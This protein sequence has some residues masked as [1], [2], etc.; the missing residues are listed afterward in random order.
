MLKEWTDVLLMHLV[1]DPKTIERLTGRLE[2]RDLADITMDM[3]RGYLWKVSRDYYEHARQPI[4]QHFLVAALCD[5]AAQ[6]GMQPDEIDVIGALIDDMYQIGPSGLNSDVALG[7]A[8]RVLEE[9]RISRPVQEMLQDGSSVTQ[10]FDTFQLG[11]SAAAVSMAEP[12]NPMT[13]WESTLGSV[14]PVP[15]GG[16]DIRYFNHLVNGGLM[17]GE[18]VI[19]LGPSGGYKSTIALDIACSIAKVDNKYTAYLSYEQSYR[20]GD[21]PIR[22]K[23]R[24]S[25]I[26]R[27]IL[28]NTAPADL[29]EDQR[30]IMKANEQFG[31]Y[32]MM[33]DRSQNVDK[34]SDIAAIVRELVSVG[35]KP[36]LIIIDQLSNW[37]Q[38]W[39]ECNSDDDSWF[40]KES[41]KIIKTLKSRVCE[42]Y[43]TRMLVLHQITAGSIMG[44]KGK[45][46]NHTESQENKSIC[47]N[48]DFGITIGLKDEHDV[49]KML[50]SKTRRGPNTDCLV[51]A[52]PKT[53]RFR[54]A[55][56]DYEESETGGFQRKG[57]RNAMDTESIDTSKMHGS[58]TAL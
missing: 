8:K 32:A 5:R 30:A 9:V 51:Q 55:S 21:I 53:C 35:K 26:D 13:D 23:A 47:N 50:G 56:D 11:L 45:T 58:D 24:L 19:M 12:I 42:E 57:Q 14:K 16:S 2:P 52:L 36:E 22:F 4:P 37:M 20:G 29:T 41:T 27:D 31:Q 46:F 1:R 38:M 43:Q 49:F 39:P 48:A 6:D 3:T 44:K 54:Y 15:L 34:V 10:L 17:P 28:M 18:I 40:R 7:Y 25:G 33:F